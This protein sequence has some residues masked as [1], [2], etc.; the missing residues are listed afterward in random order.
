MKEYNR[1][2]VRVRMRIRKNHEMVN[3]NE[4]LKISYDED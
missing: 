3:S 4:C 1:G 2:V